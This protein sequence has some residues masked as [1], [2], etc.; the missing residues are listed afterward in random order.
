MK[1][2]YTALI[3]N[4]REIINQKGE[5]SQCLTRLILLEEENRSAIE[6]DPESREAILIITGSS[7]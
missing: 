5:L 6:G 2:A 7:H 1:I 3:K 4:T